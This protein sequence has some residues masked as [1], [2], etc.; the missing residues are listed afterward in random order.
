MNNSEIL[1]KTLVSEIEFEK[2]KILEL[3]ENLKL[4]TL[5]NK[6]LNKPDKFDISAYGYIL[7]NFYNGVENILKNISKVFG[8]NVD[9]QQ[10]HSD[11]LKKMIIEVKDIRPR[12]LSEKIYLKLVDYK[13]FRH[14]FR[15]AYLFELDWNKMEYLVKDFEGII[16]DFFDEIEEF[17]EKI[18]QDFK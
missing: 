11:L 3:N 16:H 12:V 7:H 13:N 18:L 17:N 8:N 14:F 1:I 4:L 15:N 5:K 6:N 9:K 10:W 2:K